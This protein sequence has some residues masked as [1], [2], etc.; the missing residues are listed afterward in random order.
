MANR[1]G[2]LGFN[3]IELNCPVSLAELYV[4][5]A[6]RLERTFVYIYILTYAITYNYLVFISMVT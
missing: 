3:T 4:D 5:T 6:R 2:R 1:L